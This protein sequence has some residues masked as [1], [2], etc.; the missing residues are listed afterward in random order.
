[1]LPACPL[2][3]GTLNGAS[4]PASPSGGHSITAA[5]FKKIYTRITTNN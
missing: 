1:M 2:A 3:N 4:Q 5:D